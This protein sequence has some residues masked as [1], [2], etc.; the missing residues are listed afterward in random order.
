MATKLRFGQIGTSFLLCDR[1]C[2]IEGPAALVSGHSI[3][4]DPHA[5]VFQGQVC[6]SE[7][8]SPLVFPM[9]STDFT[10]PP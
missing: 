6:A 8:L 10:P 2:H 7:L 3:L 1:N 4:F 9:I 5:F